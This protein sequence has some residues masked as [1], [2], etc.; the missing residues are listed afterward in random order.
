M[1]GKR[2]RHC[3]EF[4]SGR[5]RVWLPGNESPRNRSILQMR[6]NAKAFC[7]LTSSEDYE[8]KRG[9]FICFQVPETIAHL[10]AIACVLHASRCWGNRTNG[11]RRN[12]VKVRNLN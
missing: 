11:R 5:A 8:V 7:G 12:S 3:L 10:K 2:F 4:G 1:R 9:F 6:L